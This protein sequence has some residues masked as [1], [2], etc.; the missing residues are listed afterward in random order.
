M[1]AVF[2]F[3]KHYFNV[4]EVNQTSYETCND[5][6]FV[7]NITRGGRDVVELTEAR[8]YFFLSSGGYCFHGMKVAINVEI[9]QAPA[10]APA[11]INVSPSNSGCSMDLLIN[12][13][14]RRSEMKLVAF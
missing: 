1:V 11:Q 13:R 12:H 14:L 5:Q 6:T 9:H 8:P 7:R 2:N 3:D 10:P 4:L